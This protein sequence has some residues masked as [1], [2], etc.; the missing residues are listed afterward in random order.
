MKITKAHLARIIKEEMGNTMSEAEQWI[1]GK[2][3]KAVDLA[4]D[5][6]QSPLP[7]NAREDIKDAIQMLQSI[8]EEV[9]T[10][11]RLYIVIE[12]LYAAIDNL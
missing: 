11:G 12:R 6:P 9:F 3:M 2:S 4:A 1:P 5:E 8:D 7:G 10:D